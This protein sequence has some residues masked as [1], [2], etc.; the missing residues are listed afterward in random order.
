M[1]DRKHG[2]PLQRRTRITLAV[3]VLAPVGFL[4][5]Y[6]WLT[7]LVPEP[8]CEWTDLPRDLLAFVL[9]EVVVAGV[10]LGVKRR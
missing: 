2:V 5:A 4:I 8:A 1:H 6:P 7:L 9:L 3:L 10:V